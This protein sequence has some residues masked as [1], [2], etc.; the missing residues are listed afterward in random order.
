MSGWV[1]GREL[2]DAPRDVARVVE[3]M[4]H[5]RQRGPEPLPASS[6]TW[7]ASSF[8]VNHPQP[9]VHGAVQGFESLAAHHCFLTCLGD[10]SPPR[11]RRRSLRPPSSSTPGR[12]G[13]ISR[14]AVRVR[15]PAPIESITYRDV[16]PGEVGLCQHHVPPSLPSV[17]ITPRGRPL[18]NDLPRS[19]VPSSDPLLRLT[20]QRKAFVSDRVPA[21]GR[22]TLRFDGVEAAA[23]RGQLVGLD[24]RAAPG[25]PLTVNER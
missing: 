25:R 1:L 6:T 18:A 15:S 8:P 4:Q 3:L 2:Q 5:G 24:G 14:S 9:G 22:R 11:P 23:D 21:I 10:L 20:G 7:R 19:S 16:R 17:S 12:D 13:V